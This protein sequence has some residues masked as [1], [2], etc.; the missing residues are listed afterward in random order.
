MLRSILTDPRVSEK[1]LL[2][3]MMIQLPRPS[4]WTTFKTSIR[5]SRIGKLEKDH[6]SPE[7]DPDA[8]YIDGFT[9]GQFMNLSPS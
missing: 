1:G 9:S 3:K 2:F 6:E 5:D 4:I 8:L 7:A